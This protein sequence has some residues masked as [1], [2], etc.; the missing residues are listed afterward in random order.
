MHPYSRYLEDH[1]EVP[2][3]IASRFAAVMLET[4]LRVLPDKD[5][6]VHLLEVLLPM[7]HILH[8]YD[9]N[10]NLS[11]LP[12]K[13]TDPTYYAVCCDVSLCYMLPSYASSLCYLRC[14]VPDKQEAVHLFEILSPHATSL[15]E[16]AVPAMQQPRTDFAFHLT[17]EP[18]PSSRNGEKEERTAREEAQ[19]GPVTAFG[20]QIATRCPKGAQALETRGSVLPSGLCRC[21]AMSDTGLGDAATKVL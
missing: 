11:F 18:H 4:A 20:L 8:I 13:P 3:R 19:E 12:M 1:A 21:Y 5:E 9:N 10:L 14:D 7:L 17:P 6:A 2:F 15:R 16:I